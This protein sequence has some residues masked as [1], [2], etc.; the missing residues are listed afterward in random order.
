MQSRLLQMCRN[1]YIYVHIWERVKERNKNKSVGKSHNIYYIFLFL[2][3]QIYLGDFGYLVDASAEAGPAGLTSK[4][5]YITALKDLQKWGH[6]PV[7]GVIDR[8]TLELM[9][10]PRCGVKDVKLRGHR[11]RRYILAPSKW[12]KKDLTFR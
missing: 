1:A 7:T 8:R 6:I 11:R 9:A 10:K 12:N 2:S 4:D 5:T 3:F